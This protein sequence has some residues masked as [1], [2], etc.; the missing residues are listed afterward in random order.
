MNNDLSWYTVDVKDPAKTIY[1]LKIHSL[2]IF[3]Q[4][5]HKHHQAETGKK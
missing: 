5:F 3:K 4:H 2:K 1:I